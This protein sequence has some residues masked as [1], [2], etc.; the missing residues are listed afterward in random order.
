M[1]LQPGFKGLTEIAFFLILSA[2]IGG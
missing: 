1:V 2:F